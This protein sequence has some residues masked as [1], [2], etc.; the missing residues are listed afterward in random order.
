LHD[1]AAFYWNSCAGDDQQK[2]KQI[3]ESNEVAELVRLIRRFE[4]RVDVKELLD[5]INARKMF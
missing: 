3:T 5:F 4:D 1:S 2:I